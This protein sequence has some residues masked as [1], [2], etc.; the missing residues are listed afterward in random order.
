MRPAPGRVHVRPGQQLTVSGK[1]YA[2]DC[3]DTGGDGTNTPIPSVQLA[4]ASRYRTLPLATAHPHG[5]VSSFR[6][7]IR[8][9]P[10]TSPGPAR[11]FDTAQNEVIRLLVER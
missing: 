8:I 11:I 10:T 5:P 9:P 3:H 1:F 7:A 2:S 4:F 6:V